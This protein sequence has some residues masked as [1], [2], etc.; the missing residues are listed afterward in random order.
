MQGLNLFIQ[1]GHQ[2]MGGQKDKVHKGI[3]E[4]VP[5]LR[6]TQDGNV[7]CTIYRPDQGVEISAILLQIFSLMLGGRVILVQKRVE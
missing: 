6:N 5:K 3:T 7:S 4:L 1:I 2:Q